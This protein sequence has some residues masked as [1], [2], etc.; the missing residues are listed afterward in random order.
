MQVQAASDWYTSDLMWTVVSTLVGLVVGV[1]GAWATLRSSS[2]KRQVI[3][4]ISS[5][6]QLLSGVGVQGVSVT[7]NGSPLAIPYAVTL[8]IHNSGRH[9]IVSNMFHND[10]SVDFEFGNMVVAVLSVQS[11][12]STTVAPSV[13][14]TDYSTVSLL[15]CRLA[16]DQKVH[17]HLLFDGPPSSLRVASSLVDVEVRVQYFSAEEWG[18]AGSRIRAALHRFVDHLF[19]P[20][21]TYRP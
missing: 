11:E 17:V 16:R 9:D 8:V 15:P 5:T 20:I 19:T 6:T 1:L 14:Q 4:G 2:P 21:G 18:E 13:E 3:Y 7:H 12:P 10:E